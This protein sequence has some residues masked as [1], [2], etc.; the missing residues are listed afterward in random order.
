MTLEGP[1][2]DPNEIW[3]VQH[4]EE[5]MQAVIKH[6]KSVTATARRHTLRGEGNVFEPPCHSDLQ[7]AT[8]WVAW[9]C[10]GI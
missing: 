7:A 1:P 5:E 6:R 2:Y 4:T 3:E 8:K 9:T 10:S